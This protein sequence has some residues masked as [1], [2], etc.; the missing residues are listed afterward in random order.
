MRITGTSGGDDL[1]FH[2]HQKLLIYKSVYEG[3][4]GG[5]GSIVW[6]GHSTLNLQH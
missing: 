2:K 4:G 6:T 3:M 5:Q 1:V